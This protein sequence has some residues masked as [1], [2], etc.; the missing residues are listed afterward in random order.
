VSRKR[1]ISL[2]IKKRYEQ[3]LLIP[4]LK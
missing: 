2:F 1:H 3:I 4:F